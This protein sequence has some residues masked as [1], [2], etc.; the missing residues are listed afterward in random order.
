M[1]KQQENL[2]IAK[3][4]GFGSVKL[5]PN[6]LKSNTKKIHFLF[7]HLFFSPNEYQDCLRWILEKW[8]IEADY[9]WYWWTTLKL[10]KE[11]CTI[12]WMESSIYLPTG[13]LANQVA[14]KLASWSA[15]KIL[16]PENSHVFRDEW[17]GM[18]SIHNK[19]LI[20]LS[21]GK[22]YFTLAELKNEIEYMKSEELFSGDI[23]AIVIENPIRRAN[24][25]LVPIEVIEEISEY[26]R[27]N[28][29]HL[30]LDAARLHIWACFSELKLKEYAQYFDSIYISLYKYLHAS[31]GAIL[32]ANKSLIDQVPLM[33]KSLGWSCFQ[34]WH[35]SAIALE[36]LQFIEQDWDNIKS[37]M[38]IFQEKLHDINGLQVKLIERATNIFMLDIWERN[39][40]AFNDTLINKYNILVWRCDDKWM[41]KMVVNASILSRPIEEISAAFEEAA[42]ISS[43]L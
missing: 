35:H 38:E 3:K 4:C 5:D 12:L 17:D 25:S 6:T 10:E 33:C 20:P 30:H 28:N 2:D 15:T 13:T 11:F 24:N 26:C 22:D 41:I 19:R 18:Q 29:Y 34:S 21:R 43:L 7:D 27:K 36:S 8:S 31:W 37:T 32:C 39:A 16:C 14:I 23:W 40:E 42:S 9:Y 1:S